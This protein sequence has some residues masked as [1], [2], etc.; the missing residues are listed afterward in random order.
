[1]DRQTFVERAIDAAAEATAAQREAAETARRMRVLQAERQL[2]KAMGVEV[3][4]LQDATQ[5]GGRDAADA[6]G[7]YTY[8]GYT[9]AYGRPSGREEWGLHMVAQTEDPQRYGLA[10]AFVSAPVTDWATLGLAMAAYEDWEERQASAKPDQQD[11][12]EDCYPGVLRSAPG[13]RGLL[14]EALR[15]AADYLDQQDELQ[16]DAEAAE[17]E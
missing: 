12:D 15:V 8:K 14:A 6:Y 11:E 13:T 10:A 2:A 5:S 1:M 3:D 9:F 17:G 16:R 4:E 7:S